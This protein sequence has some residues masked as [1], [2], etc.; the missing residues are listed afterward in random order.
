[1][2]AWIVPILLFAALATYGQGKDTRALLEIRGRVNNIAVSPNEIVW[3][4]TDD[5]NLFFSNDI[6]KGWYYGFAPAHDTGYSREHGSFE[7]MAFFNKDVA[8]VTGRIP[9]S[10]KSMAN[11]GYFLTRDGG[12]HWEV[13]SSGIGTA[14]RSSYADMKGNAWLVGE[15]NSIAISN[16]YAQSW[17]NRQLPFKKQGKAF[18]IHMQKGTEGIIGQ[19]NEILVTT[20]NWKTSKALPTP[21]DQRKYNKPEDARTSPIRQV[22]TWKDHYIAIQNGIAFYT[23]KKTIDWQRFP[24]GITR[25]ALDESSQKLY[26]LTHTHQVLVFKTPQSFI[27]VQNKA[28]GGGTESIQVV[29]NT[30]YVFYSSYNDYK[31]YKIN[32]DNFIEA[33]PYTSDSRIKK[34]DI[35]S[36]GK[37]MTWGATNNHIYASVNGGKDWHREY[38]ADFRPQDIKVIDDKTLI[39]W[40]GNKNFQ[41]TSG[42]KYLE[43]YKY[44][45]PISVFLKYPV[46]SFSITGAMSGCFNMEAEEIK[47]TR[48]GDTTFIAHA[49]EDKG[50]GERIPKNPKDPAP[51]RK[52]TSSRIVDSLLRGI[53]LY[54]DSIPSIADFKISA[55]DKNNYL[56][57]ARKD[58][59]GRGKDTIRYHQ[60]LKHVDSFS[61]DSV[62]RVLDAMPKYYSTNSSSITIQ[63]VNS[64]MDT[65][66]LSHEDNSTPRGW[67]LPWH[68]EYK[69]K[70]F[71]CYHL[72]LSRFIK[73]CMPPGFKNRAVLSNRYLLMN[74]AEY[75][76]E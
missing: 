1:M 34:P 35:V 18:S 58:F 11:D 29:N 44:S 3:L 27:P 72:Q 13:R 65:L 28:I 14:I 56:K 61:K 49:V 37:Q 43:D 4:I 15:G 51:L 63:F 9:A 42:A 68:A 76:F 38:V 53:N 33:I 60:L 30:A 21:L 52:T 62:K 41:Y 47:Y 8:I 74:I 73:E 75:L 16:D 36:K 6:T 54:Y 31:C 2:K 19:E 20:D 55:N 5:G 50:A 70:H 69:G 26:A 45:K 25:L 64:N 39:L 32:E 7:N 59:G 23:S 10:K 22:F 48:K 24:M 17:S 57:L 46:T 71:T 66:T 67:M 12:K 40:D